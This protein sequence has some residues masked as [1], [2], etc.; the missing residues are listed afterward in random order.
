MRAS[1]RSLQ[2]A[3]MLVHFLNVTFRFLKMFNN[4]IKS[5]LYKLKIWQT[6][7]LVAKIKRNCFWQC[8]TLVSIFSKL[9]A[10]L[11][12]ISAEALTQCDVDSSRCCSLQPR[13]NTQRSPSCKVAAEIMTCR[14]PWPR[15]R[16]SGLSSGRH[17][18]ASPLPGT[19]CCSERVAES[20][21]R[22]I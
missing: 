3:N 2:L 6:N 4:S 17:S 5:N 13:R 21:S 16:E 11:S 12:S 15:R 18:G 9:S 10:N 1:C 19:L 7:Y 22:A 20:L 8:D 14:P